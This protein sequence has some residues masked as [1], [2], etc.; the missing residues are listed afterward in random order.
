MALENAALAASGRVYAGMVEEHGD[1]VNFEEN[2]FMKAVYLLQCFTF[3]EG[4]G[5]GGRSG[6][7][8]WR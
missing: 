5:G 6:P 4:K 3:G 1:N 7:G 2:L 8:R